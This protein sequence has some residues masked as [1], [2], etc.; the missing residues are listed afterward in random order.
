M[1]EVCAIGG[2]DV[3]VHFGCLRKITF[4]KNV[5]MRGVAGMDKIKLSGFEQRN[6]SAA[7][8]ILVSTSV[9]GFHSN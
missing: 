6:S 3:S 5:S 8:R 2:H 4:C 9:D 7:A 1:G